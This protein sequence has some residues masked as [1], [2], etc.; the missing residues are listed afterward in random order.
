MER[1]LD[2]ILGSFSLGRPK[3][4]LDYTSGVDL[5]DHDFFL[6]SKSSNQDLF[7][8]ESN[9]ILSHSHFLTNYLKL[10][11]LASY[12]YLRIRHDSEFT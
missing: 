11:I 6:I 9:F 7:N 5:L 8:E 1:T 10:Q 12:N 3:G 2:P 4:N